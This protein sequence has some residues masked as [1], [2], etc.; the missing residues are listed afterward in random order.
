LPHFLPASKIQKVRILIETLGCKMNFCDSGRLAAKLA[1]MG[2][3]VFQDLENAKLKGQKFDFAICN[4]CCVTDLAEKK[5]RKKVSFLTRCANKVLATGCGVKVF[6]GN[7]SVQLCPEMQDVLQFFTNLK[8]D[9]KAKPATKVRTRI[10]LPVQTGCENFC[11][12]CIVPKARGR[13]VSFPLEQIVAQAVQAEH[14]GAKEI[15]LTGINLAAWGAS[16]TTRP[17]ESKLPALLEGI[18]QATGKVR[19]RLSSV[20]S[21]FLRSDFFTVFANPRICPHLHLSIQSG[22]E[23]ILQKMNRSHGLREIQQAARLARKAR[24]N[25]AL[26]ADFI[27]GFPGESERDFQDSC[28]LARDLSLTK[29]HVFPFSSRSGTPAADFPGQVESDEKK[30]R[31]E[32]LRTLGEKLRKEFLER[33]F[34]Q[35][36]QVLF[37]HDQTGLSENFIRVRLPGACENELQK[38]TLTRENV[39]WDL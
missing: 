6:P 23:R 22:S 21:Q 20:G 18:L 3:T 10:F 39:V 37:E 5:S 30:F 15:V 12:F 11:T 29:L 31:A 27:A 13:S 32:V 9:A 16:Q 28:Q 36:L 33:N 7:F 8:I 19:L 24:K 26:T 4:T 2:F 38:I 34:G 25:V 14:A 1:Q 35:K 17:Q